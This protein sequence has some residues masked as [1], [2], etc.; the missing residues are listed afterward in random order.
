MP[1]IQHPR[2]LLCEPYT[3]NPCPPICPPGRPTDNG[4]ARQRSLH[5]D[6]KPYNAR[7]RYFLAE[8][9]GYVKGVLKVNPKGFGFIDTDE[10]SWYVNRESMNLALNN[11]VVFAQTKSFPDGRD[12]KSTRLNSSHW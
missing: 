12:R 8:E 3:H 5:P 9:L 11:D 6:G 1:E 2:L 4:Q 10:G 7:D